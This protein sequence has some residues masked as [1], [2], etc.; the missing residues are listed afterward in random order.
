MS[1]IMFFFRVF[2]VF[3]GEHVFLPSK[4]LGTEF[5]AYETRENPSSLFASFVCFVGG[6]VTQ[7]IFRVCARQP[8]Q[9]AAIPALIA[10]IVPDTT[11]A[12]R[13]KRRF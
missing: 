7:I 12:A 5:F 10:Q 2:R 6:V 11:I 8:G 4:T 13:R 9:M 1:F 3:R